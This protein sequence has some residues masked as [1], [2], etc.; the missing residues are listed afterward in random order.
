MDSRGPLSHENWQAW[1][2]GQS[3][4][5][6]EEI[7]V[8]SDAQMFGEIVDGWGPYRFLNTVDSPRGAGYV[9]TVG[10]L[11]HDHHLDGAK[12]ENPTGLTAAQEIL[13]LASL[14]FGT[15]LRA[16]PSTRLFMPNGDPRG[17]P[18]TL[19]F[20]PEPVL[21]PTPS[22]PILPRALRCQLE[23]SIVETYPSVPAG[24]AAHL[25]RASKLY[26]DALWLAETEP[27]FSWLL[28][29]SAVEVA[30]VFDK[31]GQADPADVFTDLK[32]EMASE[33]RNRGGD[34]LLA[35]IAREFAHL[36]GSTNRFI[37]FAM[38]HAPTQGPGPNPPRL[39]AFDWSRKNLKRA[40]NTIYEYRSAALHRGEQFPFMMLMPPRELAPG[41]GISEVPLNSPDGTN[42]ELPM[43]LHTFEHV[44]RAVL[45][46]WWKS[47]ADAREKAQHSQP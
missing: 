33:L 24:A 16:G 32:A 4:R 41:D 21:S 45:L 31:H 28:L 3:L 18:R 42:R 5:S 39:F 2:N 30:A 27:A 36:L 8:M 44:V 43:L 11:R 23:R 26:Q 20:A 29:V 22:G 6:G 17:L 40:M 37:R 9:R 38:T 1:K 13:A 15:R 14:A 46:S 19:R 25:V 35:Y 12:I 47:L 10:V 34:D 7:A